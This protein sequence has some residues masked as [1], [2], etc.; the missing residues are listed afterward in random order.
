MK[1]E[2]IVKANEE[3]MGED[4]LKVIVPKG[5]E[6]SEVIKNFE[7]AA[8]YAWV[9]AGDNPEDYDEHF[10]EM[11]EY[12]EKS[13]GE[14]TFIFYLTKFCGYEVSFVVPDFTYEW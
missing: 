3:E 11:L 6:E 4:F 1:T 12:K 7:M 5:T 13:N 9:N 2:F 10:D 14:Y 8:K